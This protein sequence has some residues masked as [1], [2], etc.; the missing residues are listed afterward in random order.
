MRR[1]PVSAETGSRRDPIVRTGDAR[2]PCSHRSLFASLYFAGNLSDARYHDAGCQN[3]SASAETASADHGGS[4]HHSPY[5][6]LFWRPGRRGSARGASR[7]IPTFPA[8]C[9]PRT[10]QALRGAKTAA[11]FKRSRF[12]IKNLWRNG[13]LMHFC[14]AA[15]R[16]PAKTG[17]FAGLLLTSRL[18]FANFRNVPKDRSG[19]SRPTGTDGWH[20][21]GC[22]RFE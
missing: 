6:S 13:T 15:A 20:G 17:I 14:Y 16:F 5:S 11:P 1:L 8:R 10:A 4:T 2:P 9:R 19:N 18:A 12:N 3:A 22:F 7:F 21:R